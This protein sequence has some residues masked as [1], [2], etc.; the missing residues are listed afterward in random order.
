MAWFRVTDTN[1]WIQEN[2][3]VIQKN[4]S[5]RLQNLGKATL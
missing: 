3:E 2:T 1:V 4:F 5:F